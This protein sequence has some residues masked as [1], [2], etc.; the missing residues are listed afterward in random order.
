M[1]FQIT[2]GLWNVEN[3]LPTFLTTYIRGTCSMFLF[4]AKD[5]WN[6]ECSVCKLQGSSI[7]CLMALKTNV[8][9]CKE[10]LNTKFYGEIPPF[11]PYI[12]EY[13][14]V[15]TQTIVSSF[16]YPELVVYREIAWSENYIVHHLRT[17]GHVRSMIPYS[18]MASRTH[19]R[20]LLD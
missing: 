10:K 5:I 15:W 3:V 11:Y 18:F 14:L 4:Q 13:F 6:F 2:Q 16:I 17:I 20:S 9:S 12:L 19:K 1:C 7:C 8:L